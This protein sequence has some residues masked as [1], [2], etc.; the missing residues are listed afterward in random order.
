MLHAPSP[1]QRLLSPSLMRELQTPRVHVMASEFAEIGDVHYGFGFGVHSY[2]G[3]RVVSHG[4]KRG[5]MQGFHRNSF[6]WAAAIMRLSFRVRERSPRTGSVGQHA[7]PLHYRKSRSAQR[8]RPSNGWISNECGSTPSRQRT[9]IANVSFPCLSTP[10]PKGPIPQTG[11][12]W[13]RIACLLNV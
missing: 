11:Q 12:N 7:D 3:E 10:R 5:D 6:E 1:L 4:G 2:R 13:W 8:L 9:L